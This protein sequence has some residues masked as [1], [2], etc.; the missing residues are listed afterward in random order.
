MKFQL[1]FLFLAFTSAMVAVAYHL[2]SQR[3][4][5]DWFGVA[6]A[7]WIAEDYPTL[8]LAVKERYEDRVL[9]CGEV[10]KLEGM[11]D[12]AF[13]SRWNQYLSNKKAGYAERLE[14]VL[15]DD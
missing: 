13:G 2:H 6:T 12:K 1:W 11:R 4:P 9:T 15:A 10:K 3:Q 7:V 8:K 5:T 14:E